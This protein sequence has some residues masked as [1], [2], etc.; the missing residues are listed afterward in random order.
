VWVGRFPVMLPQ[1]PLSYFRF[2]VLIVGEENELCWIFVSYAPNVRA[3][4][5]DALKIL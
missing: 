3:L 1:F 2:F 4:F 5:E